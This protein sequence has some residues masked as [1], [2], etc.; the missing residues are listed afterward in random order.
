MSV[1]HFK[2]IFQIRL[3]GRV[4]IGGAGMCCGK[5]LTVWKFSYYAQHCFR[6]KPT[7]FLPVMSCFAFS[8]AQ[9]LPADARVLAYP[10]P[11]LAP[12]LARKFGVLLHF[13]AHLFFNLCAWEAP[14]T[15]S[16]PPNLKNN[17]PHQRN[18]QVSLS[19]ASG[20]AAVL[21]ASPYPTEPVPV[22]VP[23]VTT[24]T[25]FISVVFYAFRHR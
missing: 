17:F 15:P 10:C 4:G 18:A 16:S 21:L 19:S 11:D 7:R 6:C 22:P 20:V 2:R 3:T 12:Y 8:N 13:D 24:P 23:V 5:L 1:F 9:Q 14:L 25:H